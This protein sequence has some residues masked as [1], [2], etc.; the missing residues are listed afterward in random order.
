MCE[1]VY[2]YVKYA[3]GAIRFAKCLLFM[4]CIG[5]ELPPGISVALPSF[6]S[7]SKRNG[8]AKEVV[9]MTLLFVYTSEKT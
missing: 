2:N 3:T 6:V 7:W 4:T 5:I 1:D 9:G 8:V